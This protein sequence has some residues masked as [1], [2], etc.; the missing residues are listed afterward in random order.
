MTEIELSQFHLR[1]G[2]CSGRG[3][4]MRELSLPDLQ[5]IQL[6]AA[7]QMTDGDTE[8]TYSMR[9]ESLRIKAAIAQVTK[10]KSLKT[11]D[12]AEWTEVTEHQLQGADEWS[13]GKL[14]RGAD[15]ALLRKGYALTNGVSIEAIQAVQPGEFLMIGERSSGRGVRMRELGMD[16]VLRARVIAAGQVGRGSTTFEFGLRLEAASMCLAISHVTKRGGLKTLEGAEWVAVDEV[17]LNGA[18][19]LS[20]GALFRGPD[21]QLLRRGYDLMNGIS[22]EDLDAIEGG[23]LTVSVG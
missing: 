18:G 22:A 2:A 6:L 12:G 23:V 11:L 17:A 4:R 16:E 9:L 21:L 20:L 10:Q 15:Y 13:F 3:V 1:G 19:E 8:T 7:E 5:R 14:F